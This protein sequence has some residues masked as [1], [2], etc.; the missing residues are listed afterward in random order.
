MHRTKISSLIPWLQEALYLELLAA[1]AMRLIPVYLSPHDRAVHQAHRRHA[2]ELAPSPGP[3]DLPEPLPKPQRDTPGD[4]RHISDFPEDL[5]LHFIRHRTRDRETGD[6]EKPCAT[7][8]CG[9]SCW[10]R[11]R[12]HAGVPERLCR[13]GV[14]AAQGA[15]ARPGADR[16]SRLQP[17]R[18]AELAP[19]PEAR[20]GLGRPRREGDLRPP[21]AHPPP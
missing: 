16:G 12:R 9:C 15:E 21:E 13:P 17:R 2:F 10:R 20:R 7:A 3:V 6:L 8:P 18:I 19:W 4:D 11:P 5:R 1:N 14:H